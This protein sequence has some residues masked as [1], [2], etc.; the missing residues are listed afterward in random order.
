MVHCHL[1]DLQDLQNP[2][3]LVIQE[4]LGHLYLLL[5]LDLLSDHSDH[6]GHLDLQDLHQLR[7]QVFLL[8]QEIQWILKVH[9]FLFDLTNLSFQEILVDQTNPCHP[10]IQQNL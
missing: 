9:R 1:K 2:L 6:S 8:D 10:S 7:L 5:V 4:I 3:A